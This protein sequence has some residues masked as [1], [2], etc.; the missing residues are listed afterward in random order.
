[1]VKVL[2]QDRASRTPSIGLIGMVKEE[3][4]VVPSD[5]YNSIRVGL[6]D[7]LN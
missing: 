7:R 4:L 3:R 1:M 5:L 2:V 6:S